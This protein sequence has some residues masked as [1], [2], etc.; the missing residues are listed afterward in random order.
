M[1]ATLL[2]LMA[3]SAGWAEDFPVETT[4]SIPSAPGSDSIPVRISALDTSLT[5]F[6]LLGS[7]SCPGYFSGDLK[8]AKKT[9]AF[10][11]PERGRDYSLWSAVATCGSGPNSYSALNTYYEYAFPYRGKTLYLNFTKFIGPSSFPSGTFPDIAFQI[12]IDIASHLHPALIRRAI[13][14]SGRGRVPSREFDLK[15]RRNQGL[16]KRP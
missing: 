10:A 8:N 9:A 1:K 2:F 4:I 6:T 14:E 7:A 13:A 15:G 11:L 3:M 16:G 12:N 5:F